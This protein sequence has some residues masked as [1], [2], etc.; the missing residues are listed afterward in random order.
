MGI[1]IIARTY[2]SASTNA[3]ELIVLAALSGVALHVKS[4]R[5]HSEGKM[6]KNGK[7]GTRD[8]CFFC[9][10]GALG[11]FDVTLCQGQKKAGRATR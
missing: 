3:F 9:F 8:R 1:P 11:G 2:V 7:C 6:Q 5:M 4:G 10:V